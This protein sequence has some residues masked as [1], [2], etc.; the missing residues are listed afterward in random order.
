VKIL[1][2]SPLAHLQFAIS[3]PHPEEQANLA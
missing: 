1:K 2:I 3:K